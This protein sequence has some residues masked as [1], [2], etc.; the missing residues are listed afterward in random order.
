MCTLGDQALQFRQAFNQEINPNL[1]Q[2]GF[3]KQRLWDMQCRLIHEEHAEFQEAAEKCFAEPENNK[4]RENLVKEISDL[5]FVAFQFGAAFGLD[6]DKAMNIVFDSNMSKLDEQG[7]PIY[8]EDGKVLKG[9]RY[10]PPDLTGCYPQ[11]QT[12][13]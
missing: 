12:T 10:S 4:L 6:V 7:K 13:A 8:R 1:T 11:S 2:A 5:V 3:I 9:P